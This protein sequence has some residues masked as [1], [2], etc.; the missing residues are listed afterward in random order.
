MFL[1]GLLKTESKTGH[2][3]DRDRVSS[4]SEGEDS[5][6]E[7]SSVRKPTESWMNIPDNGDVHYQKTKETKL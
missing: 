1:Q 5:E 2:V 7:T 4:G 6:E 3:A